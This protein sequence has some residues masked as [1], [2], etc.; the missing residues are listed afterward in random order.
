MFSTEDCV[1]VLKK[2]TVKNNS[3]AEIIFERGQK[4]SA[5]HKLLNISVFAV[6][7]AKA[8]GKPSA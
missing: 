6:T 3:I 8:S 1:G 5:W 2:N 7:A 4:E